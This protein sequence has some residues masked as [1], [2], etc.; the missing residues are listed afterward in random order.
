MAQ[1][2]KDLPGNIVFTLAKLIRQVHGRLRFRVIQ[3]STIFNDVQNQ[4]CFATGASCAGYAVFLDTVYGSGL[5]EFT[6]LN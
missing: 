4:F 6:S 2:L 5:L 3:F 1:D